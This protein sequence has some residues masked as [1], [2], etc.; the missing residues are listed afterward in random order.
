MRDRARA[1]AVR[2]L[3]RRRVAAHVRRRSP[4][5][6]AAPRRAGYDSLW[7]SDHLFLDI[8]KYGGSADARRRVRADRDARRARRRGAAC[9]ARHARAL[10]G[11][12]ARR[13][14]SAKALATLDRITGGRLDVGLGAGWY[15]PEYAAIGMAMPPPGRAARAV[16]ARRTEIVTRPARRRSARRSTASSSAPTARVVDP[17]ALQQPRPPVFVGGKGDRAARAPSRRAPTAGTRAGSGPRRVPRAARRAR[18]ARAT[19]SGRDPATVWRSLGLYALVGEDETDLARR[20]ERL[21]DRDARRACS[22][23]TTLDEWRVGRLVGTVEQVREQAGGVGRRSASR[24]SSSAPGALPFQVGEPRRRR[25]DRRRRSVARAS[26]RRPTGPRRS[27]GNLRRRT[28]ERLVSMNLGPTELIIIL[29]IVL[30]I[31]GG[32]KLPE[33]RPLD[34]PGPEGVQEGPR[35]GR[36]GGPTTRPTKA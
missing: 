24:R 30:L 35:R 12:A 28:A 13:P 33:A 5:T 6:P 29:L 26:R 8:A 15:E 34:G 17:P 7:L 4:S 22:T 18:R 21:R 14:C 2:L 10:R 16:C 36:Q 11:A 20:F 19:T 31:F 9:P 1:P 25:A 23:A 27:R 32:A 3:G